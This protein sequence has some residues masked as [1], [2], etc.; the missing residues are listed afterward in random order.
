MGC[1]SRISTPEMGQGPLVPMAGLVCRNTIRD[2]LERYA[3]YNPIAVL[4]SW[5]GP[6]AQP[7]PTPY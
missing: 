4:S 1:E 6:L 2:W 5:E 7:A 3:C